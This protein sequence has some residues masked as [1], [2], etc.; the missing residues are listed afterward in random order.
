M[1]EVELAVL[2]PRDPDALIDEDAFA[3]DEFLPYW[4]ELW[5]S[6]LALARALPAD[7]AGQA[8]AEVGCGLGIPSLVAAARGADVTAIDWA[9]PAIDLLRENAARNGLILKAQVADWRTFAG[10]FDLAIAADVLYEQRN[11]EPLLELLPK[12]APIVLLAEPGRPA[13]NEFLHR[14]GELW[15]IEEVVDRVWRLTPLPD[16]Q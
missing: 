2:R 1:A 8:V 3:Q 7:L 13:G 11:V 4:A 10:S 16:V 15:T 12:L 5:P 14:G 9:A 6:A